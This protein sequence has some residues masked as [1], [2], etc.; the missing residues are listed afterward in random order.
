LFWPAAKPPLAASNS[1]ESAF[2]AKLLTFTA[3]V[4]PIDD[5]RQRAVWII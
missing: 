3:D 2:N 5:E 1:E 4:R